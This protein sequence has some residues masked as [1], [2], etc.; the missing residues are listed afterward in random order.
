M[1]YH[2]HV[3]TK[4]MTLQQMEELSMRQAYMADRFMYHYHE[5]RRVQ[6]WPFVVICFLGCVAIVAFFLITGMGI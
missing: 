3:P 5:Y 1:K 6:V 4:P 2:R